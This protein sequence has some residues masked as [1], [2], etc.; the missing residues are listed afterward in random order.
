M[1]MT[2]SGLMGAPGQAMGGAKSS[3]PSTLSSAIGSALP[4][5]AYGGLGRSGQ[6]MMSPMSGYGSLIE[7]AGQG[8]DP[9][10]FPILSLGGRGRHEGFG[11]LGAAGISARPPFPMGGQLAKAPE[12]APG[13]QMHSEDFPAL[14]GTTTAAKT[15]ESVEGVSDSTKTTVTSSAAS[16]PETRSNLNYDPASS[17]QKDRQGPATTPIG[18]PPKSN[19]RKSNQPTTVSIPPRMVQD[20]FG[21]MGLLTFIRG[22]ETDP[23][24]VALAL[25]SDLTTLGLNLNSPESLY[26]TFVSPWADGPCRPQDIDYNVP[27]EYLIHPYVR[28]KVNYIITSLIMMSS[29]H[30]VLQLANIR[31][32]RYGE[33]LLFYLYYSNGGDVMQIVA[34]NELHARDWRYHKEEKIWITRAP[35]MR[36]VKQ[37][38][39]F[40]EGTYCYFDVNL[41]R[42][43]T[44]DFRVEYDKLEDRPPL[45]T[46]LHA[47]A[48][49]G[50]AAAVS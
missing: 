20:Q 22:A 48:T 44:R 50:L 12:N 47:L 28:D 24:L 7:A 43:A 2:R 30:H 3:R 37:E 38:Q 17:G 31:V 6:G 25:G 8:F 11:M 23:N 26:N 1:G 21:M 41:W 39:T 5:G 32:G 13:F 34:A 18:P 29:L 14:P 49:G 45:P 27:Q 42:K 10:E 46:S 4:I 40:E 36:P 33:D 19:Q 15:T 9:A 16:L 35:G